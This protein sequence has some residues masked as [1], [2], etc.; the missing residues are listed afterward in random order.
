MHDQFRQ[1]ESKI[2]P[3]LPFADPRWANGQAIPSCTVSV[4]KRR[5]ERLPKKQTFA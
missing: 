1:A 5:Y 4:G 3:R 2:C